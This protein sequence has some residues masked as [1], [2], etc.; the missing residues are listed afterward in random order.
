MPLPKKG[1][2][3][4]VC[5][6]PRKYPTSLDPTCGAR[7]SIILQAARDRVMEIVET[8]HDMTAIVETVLLHQGANMTEFDRVSRTGAMN[9]SKELLQSVRHND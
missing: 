2:P 8:L 9:R 3:C 5:R 4:I 7:C 1:D 6:G